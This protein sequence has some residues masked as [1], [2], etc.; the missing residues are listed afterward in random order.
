MNAFIHSFNMVIPIIHVPASSLP[1][2]SLGSIKKMGSVPR[3]YRLI[4]CAEATANT[5][6]LLNL[7]GRNDVCQ[8]DGGDVRAVYVAGDRSAS[9]VQV[10][11]PDAAAPRRFSCVLV[12]PA[13]SP[14]PRSPSPPPSPQPPPPSPPSPPQ[15]LQEQVW[16]WWQRQQAGGVG[17]C[18]VTNPRP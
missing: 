4:T 12:T 14:P 8:T 1:P 11:C 18:M 6:V 5:A 3:G 16:V 15:P 2:G 7:L 9:S 17:F 13:A 10:A